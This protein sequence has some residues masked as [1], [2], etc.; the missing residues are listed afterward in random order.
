MADFDFFDPDFQEHTQAHFQRMQKECPFAHTENPFDWYAVT[1]E[2]DVAE[3]LRDWELWTSNS[4]PGLAHTE[5]G[6]LVSVD[7]PQ[8]LLDRRLINQAF[9]PRQLLAMEDEIVVLVEQLIDRFA[10]QFAEDEAR[11]AAIAQYKGAL[12]VQPEFTEGG[13]VAT[14]HLD[15]GFIKLSRMPNGSWGFHL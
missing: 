12:D 2:A 7:P 4:G 6:V 3:L 14:F 10:S 1:R 11:D 9:S 13:T 5:G 8:H 15:G